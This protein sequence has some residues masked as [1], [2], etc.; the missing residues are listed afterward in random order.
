VS[1][2]YV[3]DACALL[4]FLQDEPGAQMIEDLLVAD[5]TEVFVSAINLG[6][7]F[8]VI[9]RS[10][11]EAAAT[12]VETRLLETPKVR[13]LEASWARVR[14]AAKLKAGGGIS[15]ADCFGAALANEM[16]AILVTSDADFRQLESDGRTRIAWLA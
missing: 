6:E 7:V 15:F 2:R 3:L 11:G 9:H 13:V 4:A 12:E 16:D 14:S 1:R 5:D 10:F 8:Y